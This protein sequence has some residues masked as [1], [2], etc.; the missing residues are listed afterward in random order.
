MT[1][2]GQTT[3]AERG[4]SLPLQGGGSRQGPLVQAE[5]LGSTAF[6]QDY[7]IKYAYVSGAMYQGIASRKLVVA[8]ARAGMMSFFGSGGVSLGVLEDAILGIQSD[9]SGESFGMNLLAD[10]DFPAKEMQRVELFLTH[11]VRF[12][13]AAAYIAITPALVRYRLSGVH[14][15]DDQRIII[16]NTLMAKVSRPEVADVFAHPAPPELVA[17]L[18]QQGLITEQEAELAPLVPMAQDIC[19]ESD[20]AGHTDQGN[21]Y[22]LFP[23]ISRLCRDVSAR[24]R[25]QKPIRVGAAGGIGT[26]EAV[27]AAFMLGADF[28][29]TGS[30][31]QCSVEAA[32]SDE[33]K[34]LLQSINIQDTDYAPAG[35]MF[36]QG[37]KVQVLRRGV[38]FPSRA[39][40]LYQLYQQYASL[41]AI[42][43]VVKKQLEDKYFKRPLS[44]V[45]QDVRQYYQANRPQMLAK[46]EEHPKRKMAAVFRWYFAYSSRLA[47]AG[48]REN[49]VDYQVHCGPA[50]GAFNQWVKGS[51]YESWRARHVDE[52]GEML[53]QEAALMLSRQIGLITSHSLSS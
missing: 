49:Q 22:V 32:T 46:I 18:C 26:P 35:D 39:N 53:M 25:Y 23:A 4:V 47:L 34:D 43:Q 20:S 15:G 31:N 21:A 5:Q 19:V 44:D 6:R 1:H 42:P 16:P 2:L 3:R 50:L 30:V 27:M 24:Q 9:L 10:Y 36:E 41:E 11:G 33:V 13:E 52:I 40:K 14:R 45:W 51:A 28:I 48:D 12:I 37:A 29:V 38:F 7:G 17:G 8:M